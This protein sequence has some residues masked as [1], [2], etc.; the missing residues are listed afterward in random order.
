MS[1]AMRRHV[2]DLIKD[3]NQASTALR[4]KQFIKMSLDTYELQY[5]WFDVVEYIRKAMVTGVTMLFVQGSE[6]QLVCG[7]MFVVLFLVILVSLKA[8]S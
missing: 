7:N 5:V 3:A 8:A 4:D 2:L 6:I 1:L